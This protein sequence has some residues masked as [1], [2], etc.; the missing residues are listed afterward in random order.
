RSPALNASIA[1]LNRSGV[2][3][4]S[5]LAIVNEEKLRRILARMLDPEEFLS[6]FGIRSLSRYH[7]DQPYVFRAGSTEHRVDYEPAESSS[8]VFGGNS[9]WRGSIWMPING[10]LIP[11][12][13]Q[14]YVLCGDAS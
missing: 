5:M 8:G 1:P 3:G 7:R 13:R 11:S 6:D 14:S 10:L 2:C 12:L 9:N 4:R